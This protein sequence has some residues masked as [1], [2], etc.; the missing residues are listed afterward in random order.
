MLSARVSTASEVWVFIVKYNNSKLFVL[1]GE[2][3]LTAILVGLSA[4]S[5]HT[6][7]QECVYI[8]SHS[9][10]VTL[11]SRPGQQ[12]RHAAA[13]VAVPL[14]FCVIVSGSITTLKCDNII[15]NNKNKLAWCHVHIQHI[16]IAL[17]EGRKRDTNHMH[18]NEPAPKTHVSTTSR[19]SLSP[20]H[21]LGSDFRPCG[22]LN[23]YRST[24]QA[25]CH[26]CLQESDL[27]GFLERRRKG[28][29]VWMSFRERNREEVKLMW[30]LNNHQKIH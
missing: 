8:K 6:S 22:L 23:I 13:P 12:W 4:G 16:L 5:C 19:Y 20:K 17:Q 10:W 9:H 1:W 21:K 28:D 24:H 7:C 3:Y 27:W 30:P 14:W 26:Y 2:R 25:A 15:C 29:M 11:S 18:R